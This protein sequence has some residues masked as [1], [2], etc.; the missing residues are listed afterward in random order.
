MNYRKADDVIVMSG[1]TSPGNTIHDVLQRAFARAAELAVKDGATNPLEFFLIDAQSRRLL[2]MTMVVDQLG[3]KGR[4]KGGDVES[5]CGIALPWFVIVAHRGRQIGT[6][7]IDLDPRP[8][9]MSD[10]SVIGAKLKAVM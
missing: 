10:R 7:R 1:N 4:T 2:K 9:P 8:E 3:W 5:R 6:V